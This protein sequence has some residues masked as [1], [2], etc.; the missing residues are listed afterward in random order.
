[1]LGSNPRS[2][3]T[4]SARPTQIA[5]SAPYT[6]TIVLYQDS[7]DIPNR[8]GDLV[9]FSRWVHSDESPETGRICRLDGTPEENRFLDVFLHEATT[10]PFTGPA[11]KTLHTNGI[12]CGDIS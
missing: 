10:S 1:M 11:T 3:G 5:R 6:N 7:V 9:A 8:I 12:E 4:C 2:P